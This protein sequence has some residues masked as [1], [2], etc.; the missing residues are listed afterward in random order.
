MIEE[1]F[2]TLLVVM[3]RLYSPSSSI[4]W[5]MAFGLVWPDSSTLFPLVALTRLFSLAF[6]S[7]KASIS[8]MFYFL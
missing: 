1:L 3:V 4:S 7:L 6:F 2:V 5:K 8:S